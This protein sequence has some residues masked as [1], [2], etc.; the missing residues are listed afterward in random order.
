MKRYDDI[1]AWE[2]WGG[3]FNLGNGRCHLRF[4]DLR[5]EQPEG[6]GM[7]RPFLAVVT[8]LSRS[9]WKPNQMSVKSCALHAA[10]QFVRRFSVPPQ[11]LRWIEYYPPPEETVRYGQER[12]DEAE[13]TW[14]G[15]RAVYVRWKT[16]AAATERLV[17][18]ALGMADAD[19]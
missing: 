7:L 6:V 3:A 17:R 19:E 11:R 15:D 8:D 2:G 16:P 14:E 5:D 12:F 18:E 1:F 13:F 9:G 4:F 10:S